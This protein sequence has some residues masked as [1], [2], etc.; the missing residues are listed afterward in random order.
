MGVRAHR[1]GPH[2]VDEPHVRQVFGELEFWF[3]LIKVVA[4]VAFLLIG[5]A[6]VIF[7]TPIGRPEVGFQLIANNGGFLPHGLLPAI[8]IV[9]GVVFAFAGVELLGNA[10][11]ETENPEKVIPKAINTVIFRI[12]VFYVGSVL[13]LCLL[14]PYTAYQAGVSP[15]VTF[16]GSIGWDGIDAIMNMVVL[17]AALS[18]L[19]AGLYSPAGSCT[20]CPTLGR[21][22][23]CQPMNAA[24]VPYTGILLTGTVTL[25]GVGL[26]AVVP[27]KA[28]E[29]VLNGAAFGTLVCWGMLALCQ[30]KLARW[31][32]QGIAQRPATFRMPGSPYTSYLVLVFLVG[33]FILI[34]F[35]YPV[36]TWTVASLAVF[37][38]LLVAGWFA[39]RNRILA[40][41]EERLG[42]TGE[43]PLLAKR[44]LAASK[45]GAPTPTKTDPES[46]D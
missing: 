16:F 35:D 40:I 29:I 36:G 28:F 13:L 6:F 12:A 26:N 4:L 31:S 11:G 37:I 15:F 33:V 25:L 7:G 9:S 3:A 44:P 39:C 24:G 1:L 42:F 21:H 23:S 45:E 10:A 32:T 38:P 2:P 14:L 41:A 8:L 22:R 30:I 17:T 34:A 27:D 5:A 19:N 43:L 46:T 20:P 18:S